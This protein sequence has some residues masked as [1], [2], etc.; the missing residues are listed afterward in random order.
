MKSRIHGVEDILLGFEPKDAGSI[1]AGSARFCFFSGEINGNTLRL[2]KVLNLME[3]EV[4]QENVKGHK[5][6]N[7]KRLQVFEEPKDAGS[8]GSGGV[9]FLKN[10]IFAFY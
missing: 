1:P 7:K 4:R 3:R 2:P 10:A 6:R 9:E 8:G 5:T